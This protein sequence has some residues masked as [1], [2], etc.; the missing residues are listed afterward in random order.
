MPLVKPQVLKPGDKVATV[1]LSWGGAGE[2]DIRWRYEVGKERLEKIFGLEV[3]EMPHTLAGA[4]QVYENPEKRAQD[5]M[6]AFR[7]PSIKGIFSCIGGIESIRMLPYI[8][9]DVIR[10]NPKVFMGYSD[11][12]IS[13][14]ICHKAGLS[15]FYG[16]SILADLAEN[17]ELHPYVVDSMRRALF[18]TE[19]IGKIESPDVWTS[20]YLPW[21]EKNKDTAR[22]VLPNGPHVLLQ[23]QGKV[24]GRLIGGCMEVLEMA[25]G[26]DLWPGMEAFDDAILFLE[27]SE[28]TP[29]PT[30][31]ECWLRNYAAM[32][33]FKRVNGIILSKPYGE[34]HQEKYHEL[35]LKIIRE[36]EKL[37]MPILAN[38]SFGH[39][40]PMTVLPYGAMAE[41]DCAQGSLVILDSGVI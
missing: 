15:S 14:L 3:V 39:T 27:T 37:T 10:N 40:E 28:D 30:F 29:D 7:D 13:H 16:P 6:D 11:T 35:A 21:E 4:V 34:K 8:D 9:Y 20:E 31:Y 18:S 41:I 23:G 1:S 25:K 26:T 12:T 22:Q 38:V 17:V 2:P 32:G 5:L 19:A 33:I 24:K 36:E